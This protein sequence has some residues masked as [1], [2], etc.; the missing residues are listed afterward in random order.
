MKKKQKMLCFNWKKR[1]IKGGKH[2]AAMDFAEYLR[3][4]DVSENIKVYDD[5]FLRNGL[6]ERPCYI[7]K[8]R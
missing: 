1:H 8:S 3:K 2:I 5:R 6:H 7:S 4:L